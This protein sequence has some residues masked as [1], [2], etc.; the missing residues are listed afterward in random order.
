MNIIEAMEKRKSV[1]HYLPTEVPKDVLQAII[2]ICRKA[3]SSSNSQPWE[4]SV[5][6]GQALKALKRRN[7]EKFAQGDASE[8]DLPTSEWPKDSV[9]RTRQIQIAKQLF[10]ILGITR[11]DVEGRNNWRR[12]GFNYFN[13]PHV[14][15]LSYDA[16]LSLAGPLMD[17]GILAQ[18]ICLV[19]LEYGLGTCIME[20]GVFYGS[21]VRE[22]ANIPEDKRL[23][24][25]IAIGYPDWSHPANTVVSERKDAS[26][27]CAWIS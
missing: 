21:A 18:S 16:S 27:D 17:L 20:Q 22:Y 14:I 7:L 19:A 15:F 4:I 13:A 25:A 5:V 11:E 26:L 2:D 23:A 8:L 3:P 24:I 1:R 10:Q 9:Y 6:S 12:L